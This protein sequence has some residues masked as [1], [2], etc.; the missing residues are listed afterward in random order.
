M[1]PEDVAR[2]HEEMLGYELVDYAEIALPI[3]QLSIEAVSIAH[4]RFSPIQEYVLRGLSADLTVEHLYG[5]LGLEKAAVDGVLGQLTSDRL[6]R[7]AIVEVVD[8]AAEEFQLTEEGVRALE[9]EGISVPV[10]DQ[11]QIFF[12]GIHRLPTPVP[13]DQI[14]LPRDTEAGL[15][16][17]LP[18]IPANKPSVSELSVADVQR[19]LVQ[20]SGGRSEFGKDIISFKRIARYRRLFKRGIGLVFKG[21]RS[22][23]DLR[24]KIILGGVRDEDTERKF[25]EQGGLS[26]PGFIK[27]FSDSYLS[28]NLRKHLGAEIATSLLDGSESLVR[29]RAYSVAKLKLASVERKLAMVTEG[30]L[31]REEGPSLEHLKKAREDVQHAQESLNQPLV[32]SAAVYEHGE[33][34]RKALAV[35]KQSISISSLGLAGTLVDG[36]FLDGLERRLKAGL[37]VSVLVNRQVYERDRTHSEFGRPYILMQRLADQFTNLKLNVLGEDRYYHLAVDDTRMLVS[38]RPFLSNPGRIKTFEQYSGFFVQEEH[39]IKAYL[40]RIGR[41]Q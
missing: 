33:F 40:G 5:F 36:G 3:W 1:S 19:L 15:L 21:L 12:D 23:D 10:E 38:N 34:L 8:S 13:A 18:A 4:R 27:A 20:Q 41:T 11:F 29:Q 6:V 31:T 9:E 28:A 24:L 16:V 14:A 17:E 32:R 22:K 37:S 35:A 39:L 26:R 7:R 30:E 2:R 25:A